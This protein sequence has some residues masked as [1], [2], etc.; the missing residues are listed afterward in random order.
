MLNAIVVIV[1]FTCLFAYLL[2]QL[3]IAEETVVNIDLNNLRLMNETLYDQLVRYPQEVIPLFDDCLGELYAVIFLFFLSLFPLPP[4]S[5]W[6]CLFL[7]P[8]CLHKFL[9]VSFCCM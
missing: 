6:R 3:A 7:F 4:P 2:S 5:S 9:L 8:I 1:L